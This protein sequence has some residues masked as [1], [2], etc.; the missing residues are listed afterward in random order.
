MNRSC[1]SLDHLIGH[2]IRKFVNQVA[3]VSGL[4]RQQRLQIARRSPSR[5]GRR[6]LAGH[7]DCRGRRRHLH[8]LNHQFAPSGEQRRIGLQMP[9]SHR[10]WHRMPRRAAVGKQGA[11]LIGPEA[12]LASHL[13]LASGRRTRGNRQCELQESD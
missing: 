10:A 7:W 12:G 5:P 3:I 11:G 4:G 1:P 2:W 6:L 8:R 9:T 13:L